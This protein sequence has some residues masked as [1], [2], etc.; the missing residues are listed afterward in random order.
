MTS[1]FL[2]CIPE[3]KW[4]FTHH[5]KFAPLSKQFRHMVRVYGCYITAFETGKLSL[6]E[7]VS[8]FE[9]EPER[10]AIARALNEMDVRLVQVL[11][12]ITSSKVSEMKIDVFGMSMTFNEYTHVMIQHECAH[13]GVWANYAAFGEFETPKT[14]QNE[15]GL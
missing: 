10:A 4:E 8:H 15:W 6:K 14:W 12:R 13:F 1:A 5:P 2:D 7:K 3:D 11:N 9:G